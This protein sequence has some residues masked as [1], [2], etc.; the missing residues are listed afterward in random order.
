MSEENITDPNGKVYSKEEFQQL[1]NGN[2][3]RG[4]GNVETTHMF[5]IF[6]W[7]IPSLDVFVIPQLSAHGLGP[8]HKPNEHNMKYLDEYCKDSHHGVRSSIVSITHCKVKV[9][10][11][12]KFPE[13]VGAIDFSHNKIKNLRGVEFGCCADI[14]L[15][16]NKIES[17][18]DCVFPEGVVGICLDH[19]EIK[20]LHP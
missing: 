18:D 13:F 14:I 15:K 3:F 19:N 12:V 11:N 5:R 6:G 9:L 10:G 17:L 20:S 8:I 7:N 2:I 1:L 4:K 16:N